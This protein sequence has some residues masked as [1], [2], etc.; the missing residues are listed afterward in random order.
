[1]IALLFGMMLACEDK[2]LVS[3]KFLDEFTD[4]K[5]TQAEKYLE[6]QK[7]KQLE[8][9]EDTLLILGEPVEFVPKEDFMLTE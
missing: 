1:M 5:V 9:Q 8:E 7:K 2:E 3:C 4:Y 6:E